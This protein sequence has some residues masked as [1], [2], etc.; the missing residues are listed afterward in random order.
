MKESGIAVLFFYYNLAAFSKDLKKRLV[1]SR[2]I[3]V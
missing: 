3:S 1:V 2:I